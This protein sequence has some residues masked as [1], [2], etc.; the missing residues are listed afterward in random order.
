MKE[1]VACSCWIV[2]DAWG[3][4]TTQGRAETYGEPRRTRALGRTTMLQWLQ[5][6]LVGPAWNDPSNPGCGSLPPLPIAAELGQPLLR[7]DASMKS[8][9]ISVLVV[10]L[11]L[12]CVLLALPA[13]ASYP[14]YGALFVGPFAVLFLDP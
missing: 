14:G 3:W 2:G 13:V 4:A 5:E 6:R 1:W 9:P 12:F 10:S 7:G 8:A 11:V